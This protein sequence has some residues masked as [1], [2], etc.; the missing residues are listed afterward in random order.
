[1]RR[2]L[3]TLALAAFGFSGAAHAG[4]ITAGVYNLYNAYVAGY[5]V[6]GT[7][8]LDNSG[9]TTASNLTFND[10]NVA[11]PGFPVFNLP[12]ITNAYNGL[13][14]SYITTSNLGGLMA[15]YFNTTADTNGRLNLCIGNAQCGT[16]P[17]TT[18]PSTLQVY[19]FYNWSTGSNPGLATTNF[20]S[21]YLSQNNVVTNPATSVVSEPMSVLLLGTGILGLAGAARLRRA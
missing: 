11:N 14:Q 3:L 4:T 17:G 10:P 5:S 7:V 13:S 21:G 1:M 9:R 20:S 6:T 12:Y 18:D 8:T 19:G 15:L 2:T 16:S